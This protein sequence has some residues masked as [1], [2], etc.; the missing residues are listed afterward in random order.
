MSQV[1]ELTPRGDRVLVERREPPKQTAGGIALPES[2]V[3]PNR[4]SCGTVLAVGP[5]R[6]T[7]QSGALIPIDHC[8][9]GDLV[10][11]LPHQAVA[12][13]IE[14]AEPRTLFLVREGELLA[15]GEA[16]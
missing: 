5:G 6:R 10:H 14:G 9:A 13:E 2:A 12:L 7:Q 3:D 16:A 4:P 11:W 15:R 8:R 1:P